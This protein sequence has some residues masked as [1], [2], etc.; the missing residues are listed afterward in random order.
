MMQLIRVTGEAE[1]EERRWDAMWNY[2][3]QPPT[4]GDGSSRQAVPFT[5][6]L[7]QLGLGDPVE[8]ELPEVT[9]EEIERLFKSGKMGLF[10]PGM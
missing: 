7:A 9:D 3:T 6:F 10:P 8:I 2:R 1:K 4:T 5:D